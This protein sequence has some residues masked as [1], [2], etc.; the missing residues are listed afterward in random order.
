M[1][2]IV[3]LGCSSD[4]LDPLR[5]SRGDQVV[6]SSLCITRYCHYRIGGLLDTFPSACLLCVTNF[7]YPM[8]LMQQPILNCAQKGGLTFVTVAMFGSFRTMEAKVAAHFKNDSH[9]YKSNTFEVCI[10]AISSSNIHPIFCES[11]RNQS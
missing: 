11:H 4:G 7:C 2:G 9:V 8:I 1:A 5:P 10:D 6:L 3:P